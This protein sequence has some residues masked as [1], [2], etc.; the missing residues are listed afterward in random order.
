MVVFELSVQMY[1][2]QEKDVHFQNVL[3]M[4]SF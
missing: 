1:A 2:S 4:L 3:Q